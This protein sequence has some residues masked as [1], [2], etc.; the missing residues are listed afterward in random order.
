VSVSV[1]VCMCVCVCA[2]AAVW[3]PDGKYVVSGSHD[4]S[5]RLWSVEP[6]SGEAVTTTV[7]GRLSS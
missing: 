1:C 3:F 7:T 4:K 2:W 5:V 6:V